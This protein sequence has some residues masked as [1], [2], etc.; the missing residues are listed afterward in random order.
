MAVIVVITG[1]QISQAVHTLTICLKLTH[2]AV[3]K[4]ATK[5]HHLSAQPTEIRM[6]GTLQLN[7]PMAVQQR[8]L[9]QLTITIAQQHVIAVMH[10]IQIQAIA[11][12]SI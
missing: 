6:Y 3:H 10:G 12:T 7:Q 9:R 4:L 5:Q 11:H 8:V 1:T 2:I